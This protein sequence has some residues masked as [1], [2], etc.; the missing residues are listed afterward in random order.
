MKLKIQDIKKTTINPR[1]MSK[2]A[3]S[4]LRTSIEQF[5]DLSGIVWNKR[6]GEIVGG[7]HRW[8]ILTN[9]YSKDELELQ[10]L[11]DTD[12]FAIYH[13][14]EFTSYTLRVV[15]WDD[16]QASAANLTANNTHI[17]GYF[18][19]DVDDILKELTD[20]DYFN[21]LKL[22][23]LYVDIPIID[24]PKSSTDLLFG[25]EEVSESDSSFLFDDSNFENPI[26]E[27]EPTKMTGKAEVT[28]IIEGSINLASIS[29]EIT[30]LL[31][32]KYKILFINA[33]ST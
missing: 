5:G 11:G 24:T 31:K 3:R 17:S 30:E 6:S 25:D 26:E 27:Q 1:K 7:N 8:E 33:S 20:L 16:K 22:G 4:G 32:D 18:T 28:I 29:T 10:Q 23:N 21:D 2:E 14:G 12:V 19:K 15:D 9:M 13:N